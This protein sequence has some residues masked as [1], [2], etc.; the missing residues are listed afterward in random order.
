MHREKHR[1]GRLLFWA[2]SIWMLWLLFG[3]RIGY[4]H[5]AS[6]Q[7]YLARTVNLK[8]FKTI[9]NYWYVVW[10]TSDWE[11]IRHIVINL[12]GNV[13]MFVPL[14]F[15]LPLNWEKVCGFVKWLAV[16]VGVITAIEVLQMLTRLGSLDVDDLILN[17][18]GSAAG[19]GLYKLIKK[20]DC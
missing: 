4:D 11:Q 17:L 1:W 18:A 13:I 2:Y 5:G 12:V 10:R 16:V 14:G 15:F 7:E 20:P 8:P 19:Y 9:G 6:F 3:Q